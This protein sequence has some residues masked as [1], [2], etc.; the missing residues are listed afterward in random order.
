[1]QNLNEFD[2]CDQLYYAMLFLLVEQVL[3]SFNINE[4]YW[5]KFSILHF[6]V[7]LNI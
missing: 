5:I 2:V 3:V 6:E 7:T 1:M 4:I